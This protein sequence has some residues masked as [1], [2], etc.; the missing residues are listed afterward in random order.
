MQP[1]SDDIELTKPS[2]AIEP[3]VSFSVTCLPRPDIASAD[4]S[5]IVSVADTR[6]MSTKAMMA[7]ILNSGLNGISL[8]SATALTSENALKSTIPMNSAS[9]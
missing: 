2:H 6:K 8:G 1:K 4:V 9:T 3:A 5:P 7:F